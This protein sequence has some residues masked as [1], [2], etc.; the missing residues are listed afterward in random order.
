[1]TSNDKIRW[2]YKPAV[3]I[4][5]LIPIGWFGWLVTTQNLTANPTEFTNQYF[6]LWAIRILWATLAVTP[7]TIITGWKSLVRFRRLIGLF[8]F[9]YAS[10]HLTSYV[11]IDQAFDWFA[12][13]ND[14]IRGNYITLGLASLI[15]LAILAVTSPSSMTKYLRN[16]TWKRI[17]K[18]IYVAAILVSAHFILV[19][20][21]FQLEPLIYAGSLTLLL[22]IRVGFH[23]KKQPLRSLIG[24]I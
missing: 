23:L 3:W 21:G 1:M 10:L 9:F 8:A 18:G 5:C 11:L 16:K 13:Y 2:F 15:I 17:H 19:R 12:I 14:I 4:I 22:G 7:I 24:K 20:K 6:G